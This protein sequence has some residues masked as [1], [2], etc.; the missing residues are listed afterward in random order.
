MRAFPRSGPKAIFA[1]TSCGARR[2][3]CPRIARAEGP[4]R[5]LPAALSAL[6][7]MPRPRAPAAQVP[8]M[9]GYEIVE[10]LKGPCRIVWDAIAGFPALEDLLHGLGSRSADGRISCARGPAGG[11]VPLAGLSMPSGRPSP[12]RRP[13]ARRLAGGADCRAARLSV[14]AL[15]RFGKPRL[16]SATFAVF[17]KGLR[18]VRG[19]HSDRASF[20]CGGLDALQVA[21]ALYAL[22]VIS[23]GLAG[24]FLV[25]GTI[26]TTTVRY[27]AQRGN[28]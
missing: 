14:Q 6:R 5:V 11:S 4:R 10:P 22:H 2:A 19:Y 8:F 24:A 13:C 20:A 27:L 26:G 16:S 9:R 1:G 17:C 7:G 15:P 21:F 18:N 28:A 3:G 23:P 25:F 12:C